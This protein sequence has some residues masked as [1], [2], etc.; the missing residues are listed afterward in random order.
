MTESISNAPDPDSDEFL[1][2]H[3]TVEKVSPDTTADEPATD[4]ELIRTDPT[5]SEEDAAGA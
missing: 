3:N 2:E 1:D 4:A 5:L